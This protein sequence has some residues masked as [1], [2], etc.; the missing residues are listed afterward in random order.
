MDLDR[1]YIWVCF[2]F[3]I[4]LVAGGTLVLFRPKTRRLLHPFRY[5]QYFIILIYTFGFYSLWINLLFRAL[6]NDGYDGRLQSDL[7]NFLTVLGSPFLLI[8]MSMFLLWI[9]DLLE[10]KPGVFTS[11]LLCIV[12]ALLTLIFLM[13]LKFDVPSNL[14]RIYGLILI[15]CYGLAIILLSTSKSKKIGKHEKDILLALILFAALV[16][17]LLLKDLSGRPLIGLIHVFLFFLSNTAMGVWFCYTARPEAAEEIS[18]QLGSFDAFIEQYRITKRESGIITEICKG[19][20][21]QEIAD[22]FFVTVQ[23]IKDHTHRIYIKTNVRN[24]AEL[25]SLLLRKYGSE[26]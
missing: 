11:V 13:Y 10:K 23:T 8:A 9:R 19:K 14:F 3:C 2:L 22:K 6:F 15:L 5:F 17:L 4:G 16:N 25:T 24:R 26:H 1:F 18:V 21:N 20:T 12:F 7:L